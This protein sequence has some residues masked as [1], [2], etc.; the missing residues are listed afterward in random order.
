MNANDDG[1][2]LIGRWDGH[3]EDGTAPAA[4]TG[5]VAILEEYLT[6]GSSVRYGQCWIFAGVLGT[7]ESHELFNHLKPQEAYIAH[8]KLM[9]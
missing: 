2:V 4:W 6:T 5:S 8:V 3:Y 9:F 7:S 1:G